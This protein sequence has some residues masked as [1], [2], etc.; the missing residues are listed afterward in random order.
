MSRKTTISYGAVFRKVKEIEP[1]LLPT[2]IFTD[3][4]LALMNTAKD[5]YGYC[6]KRCF[7]QYNYVYIISQ[8][9]YHSN[10]QFFNLT[11]NNKIQFTI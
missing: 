4:E 5:F 2:T 1:F 10:V 7:F 9:I 11:M 3:F 6:V 8:I